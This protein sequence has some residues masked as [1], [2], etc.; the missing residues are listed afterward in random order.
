MSISSEYTKTYTSFSG[1]DIVCT[2]GSQVIGELQGITY[3]V[4][5]EKAP[6]YTMG[7]PEARSFS[8]G[9]R[10]IAGSLVFTVFDRDALISALQEHIKKEQTFHRIGGETLEYER[11]SVDQWDK[12]LTETALQGVKSD[13]NGQTASDENA[14]QIT[15]NI[16]SVA[17]PHYADEIPPFDITI[18]F[19]NEYGQKA[20]IV[21][22]AVE[23][24]NEQS[25]FS[26]DNVTSEKACSFVARRVEYMKPVDRNGAAIEGAKPISMGLQNK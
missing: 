8:R 26:I 21:L 11:I 2:F 14:Q 4:Q 19:S 25:G 24:I 5:R 3:S 13:S 23:L 18:S 9:K 16:S 10:G 15:R 17:T 20:V 7:S 1:A 6:I 12:K 22:Y